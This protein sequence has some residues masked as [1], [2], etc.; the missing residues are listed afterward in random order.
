VRVR[1][2]GDA[3]SW[4]DFVTIYEPLVVAYARKYL[5]EHAAR[6]V[7][8]DVFI[9]L[10]KELP[11][12]E[13][14]RAKGHFRTWLWKLTHSATIERLRREVRH[15]SLE[16]AY[17]DHQAATRDDRAE[18]QRESQR[19]VLE[20]ALQKLKPMEKTR[21]WACF[22]QHVRRRRSAAEV[23]AELGISP[24]NVYVNASRVLKALRK[25]CKESMG[26]LGHEP[27][28]DLPG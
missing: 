6:D 2:T 7:A 9:H 3:E 10:L 1:D 8:Q 22:E 18:F 15:Q 11:K 26:D 5:S 20:H 4:R 14:D 12:F 19:R 16:H 21:T 28:D 24:N 27:H 17:R 25:I 23:A 13:L